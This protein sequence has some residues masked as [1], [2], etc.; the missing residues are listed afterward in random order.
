M[1]EERQRRQRRESGWRWTSEDRYLRT[2]RATHQRDG[3]EVLPCSGR[4][5]DRIV[6]SS[7]Y[8]GLFRRSIEHANSATKAKLRHSVA[9][10]LRSAVVHEL[11][12]PYSLGLQESWCRLILVRRLHSWDVNF[13]E[14]VEFPAIFAADRTRLVVIA[15]SELRLHADFRAEQHLFRAS[16]TDWFEKRKSP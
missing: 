3:L 10:L 7:F 4:P 13:G 16:F 15:E 14:V 8:S 6:L 1:N 5:H 12:R 2:I 11:L 9:G